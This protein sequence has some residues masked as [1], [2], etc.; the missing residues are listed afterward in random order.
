MSLEIRLF[1]KYSLVLSYYFIFLTPNLEMRK[2]V[3]HLI[4]NI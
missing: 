4:A 3:S 1:L 2:T